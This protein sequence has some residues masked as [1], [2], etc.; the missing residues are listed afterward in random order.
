MVARKTRKIQLKR[1]SNVI[2]NSTITFNVYGHAGLMSITI[3]NV[4]K[5]I[6]IFEIS[7]YNNLPKYLFIFCKLLHS[8]KHIGI[9]TYYSHNYYYYYYKIYV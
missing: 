1:Y 8:N 4:I 7:T 9:I 2:D 3:C 5:K 6:I